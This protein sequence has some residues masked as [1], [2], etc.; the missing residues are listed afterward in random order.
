MS[1]G[2]ITRFAS[3]TCAIGAVCVT[4]ASCTVGIGDD[5]QQPLVGGVYQYSAALAEGGRVIYAGTLVLSEAGAGAI[6]GSYR[7]PGQC[8][9]PEHQTADC[10]GSVV[11]KRLPDATITFD[12]DSDR[13]HHTGRLDRDGAIRGL[14]TLSFVD[15]TTSA[16]SR[17]AGPFVSIPVR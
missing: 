3:R 6:G 10:V 12:F 17:A 14:W 5:P 8:T 11:G 16:T 4:L 13:F 1:L 7:L 9:T 2:A 15:S